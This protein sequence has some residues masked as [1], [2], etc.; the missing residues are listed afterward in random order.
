MLNFPDVE[1][2]RLLAELES[3]LSERKESFQ[4]NAPTTVREAVCA[5][6]NE[7]PRGYAPLYHIGTFTTRIEVYEALVH[8]D[9]SLARLF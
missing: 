9:R 6:A 5:F 7:H 4:G 2:E 8:D 3:D 1:L